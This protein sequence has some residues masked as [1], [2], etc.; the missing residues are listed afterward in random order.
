MERLVIDGVMDAQD[1][2]YASMSPCY[3]ATMILSECYLVLSEM[4]YKYHRRGQGIEMVLQ[5]LS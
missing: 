4:V 5:I 2:Y 3:A 1:D